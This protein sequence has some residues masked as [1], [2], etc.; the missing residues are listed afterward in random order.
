MQNAQTTRNILSGEIQGAKKDIVLI[1]AAAALLVEGWVN[2]T[3]EGVEMAREAINNGS[4]LKKLEQ[5]IGAS[6]KF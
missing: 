3:E 4:A 2:S 1:N 6:N 5:I